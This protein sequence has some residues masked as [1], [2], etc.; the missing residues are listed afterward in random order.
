MTSRLRYFKPVEGSAQGAD[1][2]AYY[3]GSSRRIRTV[4]P[5][6]MQ[7]VAPA[8]A[9]PV[10]DAQPRLLR[11]GTEWREFF[12][13]G[14]LANALNRSPV[15]IRKWET[16]GI[17]PIPTFVIRGKTERG[18][19]RLYTREQ[20]EGMLRIADEEGILH[21]EGEGIHISDTRFSERVI[22]LFRD[23]AN[24]LHDQGQAA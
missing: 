23:L 8:P 20:V 14:Q 21:H 17:I 16:S 2:H 22:E 11:V 7:L 19:R 15:T 12:T 18:N 4:N 5:D 10:W 6:T 3:P 13:I 9:E 1:V 24:R